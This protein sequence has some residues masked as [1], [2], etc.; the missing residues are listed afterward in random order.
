MGDLRR[1]GPEEDKYELQE[2]LDEGDRAKVYACT[3]LRYGNRYAA[4]IVPISDADPN[5]EKMLR[6]EIRNMRELCHPNIVNLIE[7]FEMPNEGT[8]VLLMDFAPGGNLRSKV[9]HELTLCREQAKPFR[10]LGRAERCSNYILHQ[11]LDA[12]G[13]MHEKC[14]MHRDLKLQNILIV[15]SKVESTCFELHDVKIGDLGFSKHF[16][17][18]LVR[19]TSA[20][21]IDGLVAPEVLH[22]SYDERADFWNLGII[23]YWMLCGRDPFIWEV[24]VE[25]YLDAVAHARLVKCEAWNNLS[26]HAKNVVL[27]LLTSE[28]MRRFGLHECMNHKWLVTEQAPHEPPKKSL[29]ADHVTRAAVRLI[30]GRMGAAVDSLEFQLGDNSRLRYGSS[31]GEARVEAFLQSDELLVAVM[32]ETPHAYLGNALTFYTSMGQVITLRGSDAQRRVSFVAPSD[33]QIVG[34]QFQGSQLSGIHIKDVMGT[35]SGAVQEI[36][37]RVGSSV[38]QVVFRLRSGQTHSYP[39]AGTSGGTDHSVLE[40]ALDECIVAVEQVCRE[41]YLGRSIVFYTSAGRVKVFNGNQAPG[42][43]HFAAPLGRQICGLQFEGSGLARV[44][45]C[46]HAGDLCD[47]R[48]FDIVE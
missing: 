42:S 43:R 20:F 30:A 34:L 32:Q 48:S 2:Q 44:I 23:L 7:A 22:G 40:L 45:T 24:D 19:A 41:A 35:A 11:L 26:D 38:D 9:D 3:R 6:R 17:P 47:S 37:G 25:S 21:G 28:P 36:S 15:R 46:S 12:L 39:H 4:K 10:G 31:G 27:G 5:A 8:I 29:G 1:F 33:S 14:I 16:L 18:G 13:Y